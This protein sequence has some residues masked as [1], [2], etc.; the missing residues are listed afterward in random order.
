[1]DWIKIGVIKKAHSVSASGIPLGAQ[2]NEKEFKL[3]FLDV[4]LVNR[5]SGLG[6]EVLFENDVIFHSLRGWEKIEI[7]LILLRFLVLE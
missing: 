7:R 1:M 3:F 5:A 4:G 2:I 6:A